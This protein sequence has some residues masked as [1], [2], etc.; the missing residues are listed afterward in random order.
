MALVLIICLIFIGTVS[1]SE[2]AVDNND[3]AID[4]NSYL[5]KDISVNNSKNTHSS[6]ILTNAD[7]NLKE[8]LTREVTN[9]TLISNKDKLGDRGY[10]SSHS[11]LKDS[12]LLNNDLILNLSSQNDGLD[13]IGKT[14]QTTYTE[15]YP[16]DSFTALQ[17]LVNDYS[18]GT[19]ILNRNYQYYPE[20]DSLYGAGI[21]I[22]SAI[23]II[24]NN[25]T[26]T[27]Y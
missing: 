27:K 24:G 15:E 11:T 10:S 23:N 16:D 9:N 21:T 4:S 14:N 19:L 25:Y 6:S 5:K 17:N 18:W 12:K 3:D 1:A 8:N 22:V 7:D 13:L 2:V 20:Y 26:S